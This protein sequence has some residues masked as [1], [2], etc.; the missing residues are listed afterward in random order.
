LATLLK[1]VDIILSAGSDTR[2]ADADDQLVAFPGHSPTPDDTYP[3]VMTGAD[4][5]TTLI[6]NTDNEYTYLGRLVVDF[7]AQGKIV[8]PS[9]AANQ[10]I[11]GAYASTAE[12]VAKAFNTTV[13][14]LENTAFAEGT[15]GDKVRDVTDAVQAVINVKD[16]NVFGF[17]NVYLEGERAII[18][19]EE[20]NLGDLTAE[21]AWPAEFRGRRDEPGIVE[22]MADEERLFQLRNTTRLG[23]KRQLGERIAQ[24]TQ[25]ASG[26]AAQQAAKSQEILLV[27]R[28]LK[29]VR[30]LWEK[31]LIQLNRLTTLEREAARLDGDRAQ[32]MAAEAQGRGK[33]AEIELQI[34]QIDRELAIQWSRDA[35]LFASRRAGFWDMLTID[36]TLASFAA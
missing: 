32:L 19:N 9:L 26:V 15:R 4:G 10:S 13:D 2:L 1:G 30:E 7:D 18:R 27:E 12:N 28:E 33:I 31:N 14:N 36:C 29:G 24:L 3:L 6:V 25:E 8:L 23:Q 20:T 11:N 5:G 34:T 17:S 35:W 22:L 16:G 21:V